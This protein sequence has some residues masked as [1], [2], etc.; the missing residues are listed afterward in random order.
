MRHGRLYAA[1]DV[2]RFCGVD[3]TTIHAWV[4]RGS[5]EREES[6]GGQLRF[7]RTDVV[8]F[9]RGRGFPLPSALARERPLVTLVG[10]CPPALVDAL[11][12]KAEL[13]V[14]RSPVSALLSLRTT[15][16][17]ALLLGAT[18]GFPR[19]PLSREL[20]E[21]EPRLA[22]CAL[23][24]SPS[25]ALA[26]VDVGVRVVGLADAPEAFAAAVLAVCGA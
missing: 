26:L 24:D 4:R 7:R 1:T 16:P 21:L 9:L 10:E 12:E 15:C 18:L 2:A 20:G 19:V 3:L 23:A 11:S 22:L 13:R 14:E 6:P 5:L 8:A 17:D 25:D